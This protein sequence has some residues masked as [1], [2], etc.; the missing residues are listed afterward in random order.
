MAGEPPVGDPS[1][2]RPVTAVESRTPRF[3]SPAIHADEYDAG[4]VLNTTFQVTPL[5]SSRLNVSV[6]PSTIRALI[7]GV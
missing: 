1:V 6:T 3:A 5:V 4:D 7:R 2:P